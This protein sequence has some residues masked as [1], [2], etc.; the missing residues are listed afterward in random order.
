MLGIYKFKTETEVICLLKFLFNKA[1]QLISKY[2][3]N[4]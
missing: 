3:K 1:K 2:K 4:F